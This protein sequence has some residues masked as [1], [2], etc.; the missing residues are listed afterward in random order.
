MG[1]RAL[2]AYE[3]PD[4]SY[5]CHYSH[6]GAMNLR[7]KHAITADTPFGGPDHDLGW[8]CELLDELLTSIAD[9]DIGGDLP[10]E[11][12]PDTL[13]DPRPR[14]TGVTFEE[15]ITDQLDYLHHEAFYVVSTEFEVT[16][17]R[18]LWFGLQYD[19]A[20][21]EDDPTVGHGAL[22]TVHWQD[23]E[24]INDG[25]VRGQFQALTAV[26]GDML[27][28]GMFTHQTAIEYLAETLAEWVGNN[29]DTDLIIRTP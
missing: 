21:V 26:V 14:T 28:R 10:E 6:W 16:A 24:P 9:Q 22:Q 20:V 17:Y 12:H 7:L 29:A 11:D 13:V 8:E 5:N 18:T 23:G 27:D 19:S 4:E 15:I 2:I 25:Y 1:H 3:R